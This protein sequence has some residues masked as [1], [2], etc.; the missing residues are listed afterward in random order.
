VVASGKTRHDGQIGRPL[1]GRMPSST[2]AL[3]YFVTQRVG[4]GT[5]PVGGAPM[6]QPCDPDLT[7]SLLRYA[8]DCQ[9][10]EV[11]LE[12]VFELVAQLV[13]ELLAESFEP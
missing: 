13:T 12:C 7:I 3:Q 10:Q 8:L 1:F 4:C 5:V 6:L 11:D 9:P 2:A